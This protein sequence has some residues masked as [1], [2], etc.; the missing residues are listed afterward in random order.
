MF[1]SLRLRVLGF[2]ILGA[3][4]LALPA[5]ASAADQWQRVA[6]PA[7]GGQTGFE[8]PHASQTAATVVGDTAYE[9]TLE[10]DGSI[11]LYRAR[12]RDTSWREV[13]LRRRR[14][15]APTSGLSMSTTGRTA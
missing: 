11:T 5:V 7:P 12:P 4:V 15:S 1:Q 13:G 8:D 6:D 9:A 3:C 10:R 14:P 2:L